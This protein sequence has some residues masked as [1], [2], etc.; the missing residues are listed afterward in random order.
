MSTSPRSSRSSGSFASGRQSP[1]HGFDSSA[2]LI[3]VPESEEGAN[4]A[5][6]DF[7]SDDE[8]ED[9]TNIQSERAQPSS[10]P[11]LSSITVFLYLLSPCLKLGALLVPA[12]D[13]PL[14]VALPVLFFFAALSA[15]TRQI[16]YM[17]ARYVRR[18]DLEEIILE[19]YARERGREGMRWLLRQVV[20]FNAGVFRILLS[21][22][23]L[24]AS[25]DILLPLVPK[26]LTQASMTIILAVAASPLYFGRSLASKRVIYAT[27][28]SVASWVAWFSCTAYARGKGIA[29]PTGNSTSLGVLW[30]DVSTIAFAFTTSSTVSL[31]AA[32]RGTIQSVN[33]RPKRSQSFKLLS[34][35]SVG[36]AV[37]CIL[38]LVLF[39]ASG[40]PAASQESP[41]T[42]V[43]YLTAVSN[44]ATLTLSIPSVLITAPSLPIPFSIR[45]V[46]DFPL[47]KIII[48]LVVLALSVTPL[49][50]SSV[51]SD[52]V[53]VL[54]FLS[55]YMLPAFLHITLHNFKRPLSIIVPP[56]TPSPNSGA[57]TAAASDSRHDELLQ[58]KERTLQR[59]RLGRRLVWDLGVWVLLVPVGGGG[60]VWAAGRIARKW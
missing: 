9:E 48:Y 35:L 36:L 29:V 1:I 19:T 18:A 4:S 41:S 56:N 17:L 23:Y 28:L 60:L 12:G 16:W 21:S 59:R 13:L 5:P 50:V 24:R 53:L 44:A 51:L 25:A 57:R 3:L 58:R 45:R 7:S 49:S 6:F 37:L 11:P 39:Q 22:M 15:L 47:S 10:V 20:R 38:P 31:Y 30:Q 46:T 27:W 52:V 14:K 2:A 34:A 54:A 32:L 26:E 8:T 33:T 43:K 42:T 40:T 55:T